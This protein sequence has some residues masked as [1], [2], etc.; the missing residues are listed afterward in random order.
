MMQVDGL[1]L[2]SSR[3]TTGTVTIHLVS[4]ADNLP[5][6]TPIQLVLDLRDSV[7][8]FKAVEGAYVDLRFQN[9]LKMSANGVTGADGLVHFT[10]E[11]N[12]RAPLA[13]V[14]KGINV[15]VGALP[16]RYKSAIRSIT[17]DLLVASRQQRIITIYVDPDNDGTLL[18]TVKDLNERVGALRAKWTSFKSSEAS[19]AADA[20][21]AMDARSRA[22]ATLKAIQ[23]TSAVLGPAARACEGERVNPLVPGLNAL[24][25]EIDKAAGTALQLENTLSTDLSQANALLGRCA[26][27]DAQ[28]AKQKHLHAIQTLGQLGALEKRIKVVN[29]TLTNLA[30][31]SS[32]SGD[33]YKEATLRL[34]SFDKDLQTARGAQANAAAAVDIAREAVSSGRS[35]TPGLRAEIAAA[36]A[37]QRKLAQSGRDAAIVSAGAQLQTL[38]ASLASM[39][40]LSVTS[41]AAQGSA[42]AAAKEVTAIETARQQAQQFLSGYKDAAC[43]IDPRDSVAA[44][45]EQ[46]MLNATD[47]ITDAADLPRLADECAKRGGPCMK[48]AEDA[49]LLMKEGRIPEAQAMIN[50]ART[51]G[52]SV[53]DLTQE[54]D[55]FKTIRDAAVYIETLNRAC[56]YQDAINWGNQMPASTQQWRII[57][58]ALGRSRSGLNAQTTARARIG[59]ARQA[60][61]ASNTVQMEQNFQAA[62]QAAAG[63]SCPAA[64]VA[65]ARAN[66]SVK[67]DSK[68]T[69]TAP[70]TP[71]TPP[72]AARGSYRL[73]RV[74]VTQDKVNRR[75]FFGKPLDEKSFTFRADSVAMHDVSFNSNGGP[76]LYNVMHK[77][78]YTLIPQVITPGQPVRIQLAG[79]LD[80]APPGPGYA[81]PR[82]YFNVGSV[83]LTSPGITGGGLGDINDRWTT[84]SNVDATFQVKAYPVPG[85]VLTVELVFDGIVAA[86]FIYEKQ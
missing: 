76:D 17:A 22:D 10:I 59:A 19:A 74:D 7:S 52:C 18:S 44:E 73:A 55:Y 75:D 60:A 33:V 11:E 12:P 35:V 14:R 21:A 15:E 64:E 53:A 81:K 25:D 62:E 66:T 56:R 57:I 29:A 83:D 47:R 61:Q 20:K 51:Q 80:G 70:S 65:E 3:S 24:R 48:L 16:G 28:E 50:S 85:P 46:R 26:Q 23:Q 5:G 36:Q 72:A 4:G 42:D 58:E 30:R 38:A 31:Q 13:M 79:V 27:N 41:A 63:F 67:T 9:G 71:P 32:A 43:K 82:V 77:V 54:L 6:E 34:A 84:T 86:K 2:G 1:G 40:F 69:V 39:N 78:R 68:A 49:R 37:E 8:Q 45:L